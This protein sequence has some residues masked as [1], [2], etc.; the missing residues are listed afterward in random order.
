MWTV[1]H[2]AVVAAAAAA[3]TA[4]VP[5]VFPYSHPFPFQVLS[6]VPQGVAHTHILPLIPVVLGAFPEK[7]AESA[8]GGEAAR[9][10]SIH[11]EMW[12]V[13]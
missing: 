12:S 5:A 10:G 1:K 11:E 8:N 6:P 13:Q 9:C 7:P 4:A 2:T 3:A